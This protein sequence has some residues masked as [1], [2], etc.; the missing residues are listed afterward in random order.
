MGEGSYTNDERWGWETVPYRDRVMSVVEVA[1]NYAGSQID[2]EKREL[3][4]YGVGAPTPAIAAVL[5]EAPPIIRV[6]WKQASYTLA[7]LTEEALRLLRAH[8]GRL[9]S[10]GGLSDGSGIRLTT[11]DAEL[12]EAADPRETLGARYPVTIEYGGRAIP[13]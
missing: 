9:T 7:E 3:R 12:L 11:T 4:V 8:P 2:Y 1:P 13:A 5:A 10:G 6:R